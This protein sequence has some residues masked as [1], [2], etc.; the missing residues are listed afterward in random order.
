ME[1]KQFTRQEII[2]I[3]KEQSEGAETLDLCIRHKSYS[4]EPPA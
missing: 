3:L 2:L 4:L 1:E